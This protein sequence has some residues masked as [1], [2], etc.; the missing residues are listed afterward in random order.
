MLERCTIFLFCDL[1]F[2]IYTEIFNFVVTDWKTVVW[3]SFLTLNTGTVLMFCVI[4]CCVNDCTHYLI[5]PE[6]LLTFHLCVCLKAKQAPTRIQQSA[7]SLHSSSTFTHLKTGN[8]FSRASADLCGLGLCSTGEGLERFYAEKARKLFGIGCCS[9]P[10][11]ITLK[12]SQRAQ[13][14]QCLWTCV[15]KWKTC[16]IEGLFLFLFILKGENRKGEIEGKGE[17]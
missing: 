5:N 3:L 16:P 13:I 4:H 15:S 7:S 17:L 12:L 6:E 8:S 9:S 14:F 2:I 10:L 11:I 1:F